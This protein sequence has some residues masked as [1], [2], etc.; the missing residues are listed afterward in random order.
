MILTYA[1]TA[2]M[3]Y[4]ID[5]WSE[6]NSG[7]Q[8]YAMLNSYHMVNSY[9][10]PE[11]K[12]PSNSIWD[13]VSETSNAPAILKHCQ[14]Q[15]AKYLLYSKVYTFSEDLEAMKNAVIEMLKGVQQ[16]EIGIESQ[17]FTS[18]VNLEYSSATSGELQI[19]SPS[20]WSGYEEVYTFE[21]TSS[22]TP[23]HS[24]YNT[25][26]SAA[27]KWKNDVAGTWVA[28]DVL[29]K[30]EWQTPDNTSLT[31]RFIGD[32]N[33]GDTFKIRCIPVNNIDSSPAEPKL[34]KQSRIQY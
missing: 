5:N 2:D 24:T 29:C 20:N 22:G 6:F 12:I 11:I 14:I 17:T 8:D 26:G 30:S 7:N 28:T 23:Y 27:F 31:I 19:Y 4:G 33:I 16:S 32:L 15:F 13:G 21:I 1:S 25:S 18:G 3:T 34:L 9:I 10:R